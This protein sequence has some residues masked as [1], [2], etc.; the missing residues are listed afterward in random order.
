MEDYLKE[1]HI[2][3]KSIKKAASLFKNISIKFIIETVI[4]KRIKIKKS[5]KA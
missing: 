4:S 5:F 1:K 2:L 3:D